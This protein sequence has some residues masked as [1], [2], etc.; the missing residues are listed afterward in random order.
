MQAP[1]TKARVPLPPVPNVI[2]T[3]LRGLVDGLGI[4]KWENI[5]HW[6]YTGQAP[7][8]ADLATFATNIATAWSTNMAPEAPSQTT[9]NMVNNVD[10]TSASAAGGEWSGSHAGSRGDDSIP[11]NAAVLISYPVQMRYQGGHPRSYLFVGGNADLQGATLWST[12]FQAEALNHWKSF[13]N[14]IIGSTISG[15]TISGLVCV[16]Y[17]DKEA[18]P[19]PPYRRPTPLVL[20][21]VVNEAVC[22]PAMASQ[23]RRIGRADEGAQEK[24]M[25]AVRQS[26]EAARKK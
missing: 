7:S 26:V 21:L 15:T 9:L 10:L 6:A 23:R 2:K 3:I 22:S 17:I 4:E 11:A 18:N 14:A 12:A 5:L 13:L 24:A 19:T 1:A 20:P 25:L 8:N 16:S